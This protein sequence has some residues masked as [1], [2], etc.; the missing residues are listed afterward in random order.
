MINLLQIPT[1]GEERLEME[2]MLDLVNDVL[3]LLQ[4]ISVRPRGTSAACAVPV[5][6]P[7]YHAVEMLWW[8]LGTVATA[9]QN[10]SALPDNILKFCVINFRYHT[11]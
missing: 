11:T 1:A 4:V 6:V 8:H 9:G 7:A 3:V 5:V 10:S 2:L